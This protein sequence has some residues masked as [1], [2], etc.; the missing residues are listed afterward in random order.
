MAVREP[1]IKNLLVYK[2]NQPLN[3]RET[4]RCTTQVAY[5]KWHYTK[6]HKRSHLTITPC[7]ANLYGKYIF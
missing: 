3:P 4:K 5:T 1:F 7:E 6:D 2:P